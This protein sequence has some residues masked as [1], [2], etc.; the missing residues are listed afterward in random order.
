[1]TADL[2]PADLEA[3]S[4]VDDADVE[5]AP[6]RHEKVAIVGGYGEELRNGTYLVQTGDLQ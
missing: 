3:R 2:G 5:T 1:M 4:Q 6:V